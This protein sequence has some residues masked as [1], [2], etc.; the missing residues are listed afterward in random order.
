MSLRLVLAASA[1]LA[2]AAPVLAQEAPAAPPAAE[3]KSV[4]EIAFEARGEAFQARMQG[5]GEEMQAAIANAA[6]DQA[7]ASAA[8]DAIVAQYQPEADAF[9]ADLQAFLAAEAA[10]STEEEKAEMTQVAASL[11]P[12]IQG[13]PTMVRTQIE[14]AAAAAAAAPAAA[15]PQ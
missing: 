12:M 14:Q 8:L 5:M 4:A 11:V 3:A 2:F 9:S 7:A 1:V 15:A 10:T 13:L 6:G